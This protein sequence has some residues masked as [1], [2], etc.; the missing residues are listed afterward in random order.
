MVRDEL[1]QIDELPASEGDEDKINAFLDAAERAPIN[2][3][4]IPSGL[5]ETSRPMDTRGL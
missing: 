1:D 3:R 2:S 5:C 4:T